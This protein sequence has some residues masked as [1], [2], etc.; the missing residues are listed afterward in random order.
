[1]LVLTASL[2][3]S[4]VNA[5]TQCSQLVS[6]QEDTVCL[7][8]VLC[9]I[10][11]GMLKKKCPIVI[12]QMATPLLSYMLFIFKLYSSYIKIKVNWITLQ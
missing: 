5:E 3:G 8:T 4:G 6:D 2:S 1:M 10:Q 9:G 11:D 12:R 7:I